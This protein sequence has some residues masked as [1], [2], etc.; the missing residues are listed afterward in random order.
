MLS[1]PHKTKL[2]SLASEIITESKKYNLTGYS[3]TNKFLNEQ[4]D[5]CIAAY[6]SCEKLLG[7]RILDVGSGAGMPGLVWAIISGREV[8]N[9]DSNR[10]KIKFQKEFILK[11][12]ILNATAEHSR[13]ENIKMLA[14]DTLVCKAFSSIFKT[15]QL[16]GEK[17]PKNILFLKKNDEKT[18]LEILEAK[19]LLYHYKIYPYKSNLGEMCVVEAYDSKNCN[20]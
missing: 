4:I 11:H 18:K 13:I 1:E 3:E 12:E 10:K 5:D 20:N 6:K 15:L 9:I 19:P 2:N 16:V 17:Q 8:W 7:K 14:S